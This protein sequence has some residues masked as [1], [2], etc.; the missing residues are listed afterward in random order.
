MYGIGKTCSR[1]MMSQLADLLVLMAV[2]Y[3]WHCIAIAK[4]DFYPKDFLA[5]F[6]SNGDFLYFTFQS[7][8]GRQ[9]R[10]IAWTNIGG[11]TR[12]APFEIKT[13][14]TLPD[15]TAWVIN[16]FLRNR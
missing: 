4:D 7:G 14:V 10:V 2:H 12:E 3:V 1:R 5:S 6:S 16:V 13:N 8:N 11:G 15:L 9:K